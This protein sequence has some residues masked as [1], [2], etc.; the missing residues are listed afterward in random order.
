M[1]LLNGL[2]VSDTGIIQEK[3]EIVAYISRV[4]TISYTESVLLGDPF[5]FLSNWPAFKWLKSV[6][7]LSCCTQLYKNK[8]FQDV[9]HKITGIECFR[10]VVVFFE[11]Y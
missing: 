7:S 2:A 5:N 1:N 6:P 3:A 11:N 9:F 8:W 10:K 4:D